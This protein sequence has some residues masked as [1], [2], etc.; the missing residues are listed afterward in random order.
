M[1]ARPTVFAYWPFLLGIAA[2]LQRRRPDGLTARSM[3]RW[4]ALSLLGVGVGVALVMAYNWARFGHILDTGFTRQNIAEWLA[5]LPRAVSE[6]RMGVDFPV[7]GISVLLTT[8][9]LVFLVRAW[10][11]SAWVYGGWAAVL[12]V[13][14]VL[15]IYYSTGAEQYGYRYTL[16][17]LVPAVALLAVSASPKMSLVMKASIVF[18]VL[19]GAV[20]VI[21][22]AGSWC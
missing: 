4:S 11:Q 10:R 2:E 3:V 15:L 16:D 5:G 9:T 22:W 14:A 20:G 6:C 18:S 19:M 12:A 21:W 7:E 17:L 13:L 1:L 8:P